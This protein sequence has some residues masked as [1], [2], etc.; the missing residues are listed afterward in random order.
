MTFFVVLLV[1]WVFSL[2]G[3]RVGGSG[4]PIVSLIGLLR[5]FLQ[6][7]FNLDHVTTASLMM[8]RQVGS[9]WE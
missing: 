3:G 2:F 4:S 9:K 5:A 6:I 1:V 8:D 7:M